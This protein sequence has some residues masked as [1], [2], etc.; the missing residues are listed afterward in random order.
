MLTFNINLF[1]FENFFILKKNNFITKI[2]IFN[3]KKYFFVNVNTNKN[4]TYIDD[5]GKSIKI[6]LRNYKHNS[7]LFDKLNFSLQRIFLSF[8]FK[9]KFTGKGYRIQSFAKKK[10]MNFTFW[11]SHKL[12]LSLGNTKY[13]RISKYK[14]FYEIFNLNKLNKIKNLFKK[15]KPINK[16]TLRGLRLTRTTIVKRKG[17][18]SPNL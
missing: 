11:H 7:D 17:R 5:S 18:K 9:I 12:I 6:N 13:K 3:E 16:Y 10:I 2:L 1:G 4:G 8:F 15:V 14:Y